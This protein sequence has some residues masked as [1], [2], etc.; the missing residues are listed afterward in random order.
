MPLLRLRGLLSGAWLGIVIC[1]AAFAAPAAFAVLERADA[2]RFVGRLFAMEAA[3][4]LAL[5]MLLIL[6][7]RRLTRDEPRVIT[8][9]FLLAAGALF[10]T[11]A[12]YYAVQPQMEAARAGQGT[13]SFGA[14][15]AISAGALTLKG[16][17]LLVLAWRSSAA[18]ASK[19][20]TAPERSTS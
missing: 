4:S 18:H 6:I 16:V 14:L 20:P 9:E 7:E 13:L 15:H 12:G 17:L 19:Q 1:V 5:A 8:A 3:A 2:G 11:V 10:C